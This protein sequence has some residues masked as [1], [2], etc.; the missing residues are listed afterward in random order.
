MR[1]VAARRRPAAVPDAHRAALVRGGWGWDAATRSLFQEHTGAVGAEVERLRDPVAAATYADL[2]VQRAAR[3]TRVYREVFHCAPD[4][5]VATWDDYKQFVALPGPPP[6]RALEL[7]AGVHG[8][9]V[10]FPLSFLKS[11]SL[12]GTTLS[13]GESLVSHEVFL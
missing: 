11:E 2:L 6:A 7:L 9:L 8:H 12:L 3:N 5:G 4:D 1:A 13:N 10:Q